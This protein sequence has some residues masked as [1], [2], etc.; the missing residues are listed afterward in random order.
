MI[1]LQRRFSNVIVME[2]E[3]CPTLEAGAGEGG[4]NLPMIVC[5]VVTKGNGEAWLMPEKHMSLS[6][7]GGQAGQGYPCIV[8][9][10]EADNT[11]GKEI[12]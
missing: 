11:N 7:G 2:S 6:I 3:I 4:N 10:N 12:L 5:G 8:I 9:V 1:V